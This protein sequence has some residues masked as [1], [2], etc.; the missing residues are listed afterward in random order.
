MD[1]VRER[2]REHRNERVS[3]VWKQIFDILLR[4]NF[5]SNAKKKLGIFNLS[6]IHLRKLW[7]S[8]SN[9]VHAIFNA[10]LYSFYKY[11]L[12]YS[13]CLKI[14]IQFNSMT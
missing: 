1:L 11:F 6:K 9:K 7:F 4:C 5:I 3:N 12:Q 13:Y 14:Y 10:E 2:F 8:T